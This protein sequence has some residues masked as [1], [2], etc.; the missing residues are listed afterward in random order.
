M[1][2]VASI[3]VPENIK[4][5]SSVSDSKNK[6][7]FSNK[8]LPHLGVR[9]TLCSLCALSISIAVYGPSRSENSIATES[10]ID[11]IIL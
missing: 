5:M 8:W 6:A 4:C 1:E 10:K 7:Q 11:D 2:L 9:Y 3:Y